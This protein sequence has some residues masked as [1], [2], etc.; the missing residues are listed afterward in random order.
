M[1]MIHEAGAPDMPKDNFASA[2]ENADRSVAE[3]LKRIS[4]VAAALVGEAPPEG[5]GVPL[6]SVPVGLLGSVEDRAH[7]IMGKVQSAHRLIDRIERALP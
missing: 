6:Q 1:A 4:V 7:A 2:V 3:L 5:E